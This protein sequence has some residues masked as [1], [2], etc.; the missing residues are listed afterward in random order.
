M[1]QSLPKLLAINTGLHNAQHKQ[2]WQS[3]MDKIVAKVTNTE[4]PS[5]QSGIHNNAL[6]S[7][8]P[9]RYGDHCSR[10]GCRFRHSFDNIPP[11]APVNNPYCSNNWLP[12]SISLSLTN[13]ELVI[14]KIGDNTNNCSKASEDTIEHDDEKTKANN[15]DSCKKVYDLTAVVCFINDQSSSEKR[16]IVALVKIPE[17]YKTVNSHFDH[18]W[19]LFNDFTIS[20]V[21]AQEAVW[22]SLDWKIPCVLY[23]STR[24]IADS[25]SSIIQPI[26]KVGCSVLCDLGI[27][28]IQ[29]RN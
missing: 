16:N 24:D 22:F 25:R 28:S 8:K 7:S 12:H 15:E 4:I 13:G 1:F 9:C 14:D 5:P 10:P 20:P 27:I 6:S 2:F 23:Y 19:Y 17:T 11:P 29:N 18:K 26:T 3:Q 21:S